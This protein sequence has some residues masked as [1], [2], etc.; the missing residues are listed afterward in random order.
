[1]RTGAGGIPVE[2]IAGVE[3]EPANTM[4]EQYTAVR[5]VLEARLNELFVWN[6]P[7]DDIAY[8][9][10]EVLLADFAGRSYFIE[11][12]RGEQ[13]EWV[14]LYEMDGLHTKR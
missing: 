3:I 9:V 13:H 6:A 2:I 12:G 4:V 7:D 11:V 10:E 8:A 5:L 14:Q 1:M